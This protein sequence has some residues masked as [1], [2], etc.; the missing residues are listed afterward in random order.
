MAMQWGL[1]LIGIIIVGFG[2]YFLYRHITS[3]A[4]ASLTVFVFGAGMAWTAYG[5]PVVIEAFDIIVRINQAEKKAEKAQKDA[6]EAKKKADNA[7]KQSGAALA[8][9]KALIARNKTL[10][11][12]FEAQTNVLS[13]WKSQDSEIIKKVVSSG[14]FKG[15]VLQAVGDAVKPETYGATKWI[16]APTD[17]LEW[18][19]ISAQLAAQGVKMNFL[20]HGEVN[21]LINQIYSEP[22]SPTMQG[23]SPGA[24]IYSEPKSPTMQGASPGAPVYSEP[25]SPTMQG[26][27]PGAPITK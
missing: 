23:A 26:A 20:K 25:K 15:A 12:K 13:A 17:S 5:S 22:K 7:I 19:K 2:L 27:S 6:T 4:N 11:A 21:K 16:V 18:A 3:H 9:N 24:P 1:F 10:L 14:D 8:E